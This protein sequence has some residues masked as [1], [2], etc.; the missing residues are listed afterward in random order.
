MG[1]GKRVG[2]PGASLGTTVAE[3]PPNHSAG[4]GSAP[5]VDWEWAT[6]FTAM[7]GRGEEERLILTVFP[8][9]PDQPNIHLP[10]DLGDAHR[11]E[12]E[13]TLR[14]HPH[15]AL[16]LIPNPALPQPAGWGSRPEEQRRDGSPRVWGASNDH[17]SGAVGIWAE[18]DGGLSIEEQEKLPALAGLLS[19]P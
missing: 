18:C 15:H 12:V 5:L 4:A 16:G 7:L 10:G 19:R 11:R 14:K 3:N 13:R 6:A 8:P 17:I 2:A 9:S 1:E